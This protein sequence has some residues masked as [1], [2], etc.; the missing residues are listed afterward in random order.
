M[1]AEELAESRRI[2]EVLASGFDASAADAVASPA[3]DKT[4]RV[5]K[6]DITYELVQPMVSPSIY[7]LVNGQNVAIGYLGYCLKVE[8]YRR[9]T[10]LILALEAWRIE[11][12]GLPK[13]LDDLTPKYLDKVPVD[14]YIGKTFGYEPAGFP[15]GIVSEPGYAATRMLEPGRPFIACDTSSAETYYA[16]AEI[17]QRSSAGSGFDESKGVCIVWKGVWVFPIPTSG[18]KPPAVQPKQ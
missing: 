16:D 6:R 10:R 1:T 8:T 15:C 3:D 7:V 4:V 11:H 13:S 17:H 5:P 18:E 2:E 9:A 14:P 12:G